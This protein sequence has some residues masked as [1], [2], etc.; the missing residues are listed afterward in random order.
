MEGGRGSTEEGRSS[1]GIK[2]T[3]GPVRQP[4]AIVDFI[5]QSG[6]M[7]L[8]TVQENGAEGKGAQRKNPGY[9]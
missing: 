5:P 1:G 3:G 7:N 9:V 6:T 2:S 8:A 4:Y